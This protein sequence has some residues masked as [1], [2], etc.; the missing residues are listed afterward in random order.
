[1]YFIFELGNLILNAI[2]RGRGV[3]GSWTQVCYPDYG[4]NYLS[5]GY[6][7]EGCSSS[8]PGWC[9][10]S[11]RIAIYL[12]LGSK[13]GW[14]NR[15]SSIN[16]DPSSTLSINDLNWNLNCFSPLDHFH[17]VSQWQTDAA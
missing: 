3:V 10:L 1:M 15:I 7:R 16:A 17:S 8:G 5:S 13:D 9:A 14:E 4:L 2:T 6:K 12:T 11:F